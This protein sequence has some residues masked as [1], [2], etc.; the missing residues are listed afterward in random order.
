MKQRHFS[1]LRTCLPV[2]AVI[3]CSLLCSCGTTGHIR[4]YDYNVSKDTLRSAI[5]QLLSANPA[6]NFPNNDS[7]WK[8][9]ISADSVTDWFADNDGH[10]HR[11]YRQLWD[12][13]EYIYFKNKREEVYKLHYYRD[14][15]YWNRNPYYSR[16]A[17]VGVVKKGGKWGYADPIFGIFFRGKRRVEKRLEK[18]I[19]DKLPYKFEKME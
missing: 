18:E 17:L 11:R 10:L 15:D 1:F 14:R 5:K 8:P 6:Y 9:Y 13:E 3:S 7:A 19:L 16:L 12:K 2:I 4:F